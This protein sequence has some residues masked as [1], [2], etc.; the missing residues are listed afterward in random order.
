MF[1]KQIVIIFVCFNLFVINVNAT[2]NIEN[3]TQ[4]ITEIT[5]EAELD[6]LYTKRRALYEAY[7]EIDQE[8]FKLHK[9]ILEGINNKKN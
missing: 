7:L 1:F 9:E 6:R 3:R 5:K 8:I 4:G 2:S